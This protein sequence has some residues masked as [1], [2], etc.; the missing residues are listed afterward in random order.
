MTQLGFPGRCNTHR[1]VKRSQDV[2]ERVIK[3]RYCGIR[4]GGRRKGRQEE[5][6]Q[7]SLEVNKQEVRATNQQLESRGQSERL[8]QPDIIRSKCGSCEWRLRGREG[9]RTQKARKE[10][11]RQ[12]VCC[13]GHRLDIKTAEQRRD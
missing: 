6:G 5:W 10:L 13:T 7:S 2:V 9:E 3:V 11:S 4:A 1:Q 12:L 8:T